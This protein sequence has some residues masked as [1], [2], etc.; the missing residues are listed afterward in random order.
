M[1][2][3]GAL[4]FETSYSH[5]YPTLLAFGDLLSYTRSPRSDFKVSEVNSAFWF[6]LFNAGAFWVVVC[7]LRRRT[8]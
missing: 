1:W 5:N 4:G 6:L 8:H 2:V 3:R 7:L